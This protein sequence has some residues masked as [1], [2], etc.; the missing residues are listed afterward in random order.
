MREDAKL[1]RPSPRRQRRP[2]AFRHRPAAPPIRVTSGSS[3]R[4]SA[5]P[6]TRPS[7][8]DRRCLPRAARRLRSASDRPRRRRGAPRPRVQPGSVTQPWATRTMSASGRQHDVGQSL[9]QRS[10]DDAGASGSHELQGALRAR[11]AAAARAQTPPTDGPAALPRANAWRGR[12]GAADSS[13]RPTVATARK[14]ARPTQRRE[15]GLR[16]RSVADHDH[17]GR[18]LAGNGRARRSA[19]HPSASSS[20]GS[21]KGSSLHR[22]VHVPVHG[23]DSCTCTRTCT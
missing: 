20:N 13:P 5:S 6:C 18:R 22:T 3:A 15:P 4:T 14:P 17:L 8:R 1:H 10:L 19:S 16:P 2:R 12:S 23:C 7:A 11:R 21:S 9:V